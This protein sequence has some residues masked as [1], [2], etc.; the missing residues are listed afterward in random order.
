MKDENWKIHPLAD[1]FPMMSEEE[2]DELASDIKTN[3]LQH[4]I[5]RDKNN[6]I[7]D[8]RN[9]LEA[10]RRAEIKPEFTILEDGKDPVAFIISENVTRRHLTKGQRAMLAAK[11]RQLGFSETKKNLG[12]SK[13]TLREIEEQINIAHSHIAYALVILDFAPDLEVAVMSGSMTLNEAY[14]QAKERQIDANSDEALMFRLKRD[15]P[16]LAEEVTEE[17]LTLGNGIKAL[18]ERIEQRRRRCRS[19]AGSLDNILIFTGAISASTPESMIAELKE[20]LEPES[21]TANL[22]EANSETFKRA[23]KVLSGLTKDWKK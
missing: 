11:G 9:R 20:Y 13:T 10:C 2:L 15:A 1:L 19:V 3:G 21:F 14:K 17:K 6:N 5:V 18:E 7:I 12:F 22:K 4:P 16:D 8:G 23:I